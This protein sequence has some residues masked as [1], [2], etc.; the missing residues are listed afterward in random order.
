MNELQQQDKELTA[1]WEGE[2]GDIDQIK[3]I[4]EKIEGAQNQFE[5]A[6][7]KG[8]LET[9]ARLKYETIT[10]LKKELDEKEAQL[11]ASDKS[12]IQN[13]VNKEHVAQIVAKWTG[14]PMS[15][16]LCWRPYCAWPKA[17]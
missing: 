10:N 6:Q 3:Q 17:A 4:K 8:D 14:I 1:K 16:L 11:S 13:E 15:R 12:V 7:R 2:R 9:A 5:N